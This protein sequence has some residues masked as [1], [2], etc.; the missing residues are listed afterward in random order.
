MRDPRNWNR[1]VRAVLVVDEFTQEANMEVALGRQSGLGED[2]FISQ[3][4][5]IIPVD[6]FRLFTLIYET[7]FHSCTDEQFC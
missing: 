1:Q 7:C 6:L 3:A 4:R 2:V 5:N